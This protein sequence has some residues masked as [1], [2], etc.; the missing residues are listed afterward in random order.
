MFSFNSSA[1]TVIYKDGGYGSFE[2]AL[3][4]VVNGDYYDIFFMVNDSLE[5][6]KIE[7]S[8]VAT[9]VFGLVDN[10]I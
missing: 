1:I 6:T 3:K 4:W 8:K 2:H 10:A 9:I 7:C 5:Y